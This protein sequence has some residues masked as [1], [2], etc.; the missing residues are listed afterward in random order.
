MS[1]LNADEAEGLLIEARLLILLGRGAKGRGG[2]KKAARHWRKHFDDWLSRQEL[3][4][5]QALTDEW[6]D[7]VQDWS[8]VKLTVEQDQ[9]LEWME[10]YREYRDSRQQPVCTCPRGRHFSLCPM[11][12]AS[13]S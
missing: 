10:R 7:E 6:T 1:D 13:S 8:K 5:G 11:S 3:P 4:L 2:W 12:G 9:S